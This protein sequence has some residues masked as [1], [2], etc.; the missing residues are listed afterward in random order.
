MVS[1]TFSD[2]IGDEGFSAGDVFCLFKTLI[3][4]DTDSTTLLFTPVGEETL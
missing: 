1:L 3:N 2:V 4:V